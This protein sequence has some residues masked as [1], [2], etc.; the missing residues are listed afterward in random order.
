MY[1]FYI[2]YLFF[3]FETILT[4]TIVDSVSFSKSIF[5]DN[6]YNVDYFFNAELF[7]SILPE[8]IITFFILYSL[9]T[10]FST[11]KNYI[12]FYYRWI[13]IFLFIFLLVF[14]NFISCLFFIFFGSIEPNNSYLT[15]IITQKFSTKI[16]F[17]YT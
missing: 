8:F 15:V 14:W 6:F 9:I 17:G 7:F 2:S 4:L 16:L 5:R 3:W 11:K 1:Y 12:I 10:L 13:F